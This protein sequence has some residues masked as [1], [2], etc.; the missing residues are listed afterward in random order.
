[1]APCL[2]K[3]VLM[4]LQMDHLPYLEENHIRV[5]FEASPRVYKPEEFFTL[6]KEHN[7]TVTQV[8]QCGPRILPEEEAAGFLQ[9][10]LFF[11]LLAQVLDQPIDAGQ[12]LRQRH[13]KLEV[14]TEDLKDLFN[15]ST[16]RKL[17]RVQTSLYDD[18]ERQ[19]RIRAS[20]ALDEARKFV[21]TWCSDNEHGQNLD[22]DSSSPNNDWSVSGDSIFRSRF[23]E[24]CLSFGIL[25]E[26]LDR[27]RTRHRP[28][29][30][31]E[32]SGPY[33][34][35]HDQV[36]DYRGWGY[37][38]LLRRRM[39]R[40]GWCPHDVRRIN[41]TAGDLSSIYYVSSS[42][43]VQK[44]DHSA[45]GVQYCIAKP[46]SISEQHTKQWPYSEGVGVGVMPDE[47]ELI[48]IVSAGNIP[49]LKYTNTEELNL[50]E[51]I[52]PDGTKGYDETKS[53]HQPRFVA[54]SHAWSDGL[55]PS[56]GRGLPQCQLVRLRDTLR[57]HP[58]TKDLPFWIDSLCVPR[59][60][61]LKNKAIQN[62]GKVYSHAFTVLVLDSNL[63]STSSLPDTL[64]ATIRINTGIWSQRM[65]TLPEGVLAR[66]LHF[67]FKEGLLSAEELRKRYERAKWD[68]TDREHH[69]YKAGWLFSPYMFSMRTQ[70][71]TIKG[72]SDKGRAEHLRIAHVWQAMQ[73]RETTRTEDETLCLARLLDIDPLSL[74]GI[75]ESQGE[76]VD[77]RRMVEFLSLLDQK[78]GMP[79]GM[80]FL[81]G[82][83][84][85]IKGFRWAP[86]TWMRKQSREFADP[87]F[88]RDQKLSFLTRNGLHVQYPAIQLHPGKK[89]V[90][91]RFWIPTARNLTKWYRI[92]YIPGDKSA[93]SWKEIWELACSG[94]QL[95]A[96]VRSR[97]DRHDEPEV[98]LLVKG[99]GSREK[100]RT[101]SQASRTREDVRW[102][103]SLCRVWIQW[104]TDHAIAQKLAEE[105]R[106]NIDQMTW[107]DSLEAD[108]RWVVD[109]YCWDEEQIATDKAGLNPGKRSFEIFKQDLDQDHLRI[110]PGVD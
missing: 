72:T 40:T 37:S 109:G 62:M 47:K 9:A 45:C 35:W 23:P 53:D 44:A 4:N 59:P 99:I 52:V 11:S 54:I 8:L 25:G 56:N 103:H 46:L 83:K 13:G 95:P 79:P 29:T 17:S 86:N 49:L 50:M 85:N 12:F 41:M 39:Q 80:I 3:K 5:A 93:H 96:I 2:F 22:D 104:E 107:G 71:D 92:E 1:M 88:V 65:W 64:E 89:F 18:N 27:F 63:R 101:Q 102:A 106:Y 67:D 19:H 38:D 110:P 66:N 55:G 77:V 15:Q 105:F 42:H 57:K 33:G 97:F 91:S 43:P 7:C 21:V 90:E 58:D 34:S 68:P 51:Y 100:E 94:E 24:L 82:P 74:L 31:R 75:V 61:E 48:R 108:Q 14:S 32:D 20:L 84:L 30:S 28:W 73:W 81:P 78:T 87:L 36:N 6:P 76:S 98:G 10:W 26:T 60:V 69:V 16:P 70:L